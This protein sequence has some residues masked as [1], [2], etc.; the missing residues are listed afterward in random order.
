MSESNT[1]DSPDDGI[2]VANNESSGFLDRLGAMRRI[3]WGA[4]AFLA[5]LAAL[6]TFRIYT[7]VSRV[8]STFVAP[9][10]EPIFQAAFN[11]AVLL[12]AVAGIAA[13]SSRMGTESEG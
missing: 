7:N 4:I 2:E 1:N 6:A 12:L 10:Y 13:L 8:I 9:E 11:L 3:E 5:I